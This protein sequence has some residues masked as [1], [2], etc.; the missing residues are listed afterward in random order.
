MLQLFRK[1]YIRAPDEFLVELKSTNQL[2][3]NEY[4]NADVKFNDDGTVT[5]IFDEK[6]EAVN[7]FLPKIKNGK[8]TSVI[9]EYSSTGNNL[10]YSLYDGTSRFR[11][12]DEWE[13][14]GKRTN[15]DKD[16]ITGTDI[17]KTI[18]NT[19]VSDCEVIRGIGISNPSKDGVTTITIKKIL[20]M[21]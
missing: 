17:T 6:Y 7:F 12:D 10:M 19:D 5:I 20:F 8:Y 4:N 1:E 2:I 9:L 15:W 3:E 16:I 14:D 13:D 21:K 11:P 18:K